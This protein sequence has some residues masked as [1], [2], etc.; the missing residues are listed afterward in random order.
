[1]SHHWSEKFS[2]LKIIALSL[3]DNVVTSD[4]NALVIFWAV[5]VP[6]IV[7]SLVTSEPLS[8]PTVI[9]MRG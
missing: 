6:L 5:L 7:I 2:L 9:F 3:K 8:L 4:S 1:L